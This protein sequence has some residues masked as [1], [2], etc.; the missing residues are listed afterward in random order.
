MS[1]GA[2]VIGPD[3]SSARAA[4]LMTKYDIGRLPVL[5]QE[6]LVGII[7]RSD[8]MHDLYG[9]CSIDKPPIGCQEERG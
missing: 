8:A 6:R 5:E 2:V 4:Q 1:T 7:T 3:E 9:Y